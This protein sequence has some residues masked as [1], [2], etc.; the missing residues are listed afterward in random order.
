MKISIWIFCCLAIALVTLPAPAG[1]HISNLASDIQAAA[2]SIFD[3]SS[4]KDEM[5]M[6][7]V[8]LVKALGGVAR[9]GLPANFSAK[10]D[11]AYSRFQDTG[12]FDPEGISNLHGAW[13][14]LT[15]GEKFSFPPELTSIEEIVEY[16]R[17]KIETGLQ[18]LR[19]GDSQGAAKEILAVLLMIVTPSSE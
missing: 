18:A 12:M 17:D 1:Q 4:E 7:F 8:A 15:S 5:R 14:V 2:D 19:S 3:R 13:E 9:K 6:G 11:S 10:V 16:A